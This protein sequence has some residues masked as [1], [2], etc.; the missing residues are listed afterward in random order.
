MYTLDLTGSGRNPHFDYVYRTT[1]MVA[2]LRDEDGS[3]V[4]EGVV[5]EWIIGDRVVQTGLNFLSLSREDVGHSVTVHALVSGTDGETTTVTT[6]TSFP[7]HEVK[8]LDGDAV[9]NTHGFIEL[10][11]SNEPGQ[12]LHAKVVDPNIPNLI[13]YAWEVADADGQ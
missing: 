6:P 13:H 2:V 9:H 1:M 8:G 10:D 12:V 11:G 3:P 5:Y 4:L 7:I